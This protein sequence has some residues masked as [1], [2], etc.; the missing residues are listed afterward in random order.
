M[1][2]QVDANMGGSPGYRPLAAGPVPQHEGDVRPVERTLLDPGQARQR[3]LG[4]R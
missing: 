4:R 2:L 3:R 1:A